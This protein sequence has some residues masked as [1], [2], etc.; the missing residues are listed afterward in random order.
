MN[1]LVCF[2]SRPKVIF[3]NIDLEEESRSLLLKVP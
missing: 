2:D 1:L 3:D